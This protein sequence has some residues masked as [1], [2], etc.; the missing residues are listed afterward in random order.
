MDWT[1]HIITF[2]AGVVCGGAAGYIALNGRLI[3]LETQ[4]DSLFRTIGRL[5]KE[6]NNLKSEK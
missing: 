3:K 4:I 6:L 5:E 2:L 1:I